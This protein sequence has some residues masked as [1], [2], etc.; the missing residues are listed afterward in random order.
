[1][2]SVHCQKKVAAWCGDFGFGDRLTFLF[3]WSKRG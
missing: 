2:L 3:Q 1:M